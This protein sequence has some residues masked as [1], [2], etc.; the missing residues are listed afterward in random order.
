[1][2][3]ENAFLGFSYSHIYFTTRFNSDN[4]IKVEQNK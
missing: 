4:F 1:M 3:D 2:L